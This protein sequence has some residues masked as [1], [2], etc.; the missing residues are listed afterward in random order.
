MTAGTG[1]ERNAALRWTGRDD[2]GDLLLHGDGATATLGPTGCTAFGLRLGG[3]AAL[4]QMCGDA[5]IGCRFGRAPGRCAGVGSG[6]RRSGVCLC[7]LASLLSPLEEMLWN[8]SH[9]SPRSHVRILI[10]D[11]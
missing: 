8:L 5:R 4:E 1:T 11:H 3:P 6:G 7:L 2:A 9:A 10:A